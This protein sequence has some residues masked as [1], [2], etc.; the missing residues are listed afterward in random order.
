MPSLIHAVEHHA[1]DKKD[2]IG[3]LGILFMG[4]LSPL[5]WVCNSKYGGAGS[6][7]WSHPNS[8]KEFHF[9]NGGHGIL[10]VKDRL[11]NGKHVI[12]LRGESDCR[13][14]VKLALS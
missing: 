1:R 7:F 11:R 13:K 8:T 10:H 4:D 14:L 9:R 2:L 5:G 6:Y 12:A 3:Y